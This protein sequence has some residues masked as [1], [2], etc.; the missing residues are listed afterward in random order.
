MLRRAYGGQRGIP[1]CVYDDQAL[2]GEPADR[3]T[4]GVILI[5]ILSASSYRETREPR[6]RPPERSPPC[7]LRCHAWC[8]SLGTQ[9]QP[10]AGRRSNPHDDL[11][12][13][14]P[15]ACR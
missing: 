13:V 12:E 7:E 2:A 11:P 4:Q 10:A 5:C 8:A 3:S 6:V 1:V 14:R 9:R 15:S